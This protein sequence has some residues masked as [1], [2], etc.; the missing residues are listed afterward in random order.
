MVH[1]VAF[2]IRNMKIVLFAGLMILNMT[3]LS[4]ELTLQLKAACRVSV[5]HVLKVLL[6]GH[7]TR[8]NNIQ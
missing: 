5:M 4:L 6:S 8:P 1:S 2:E 3:F 7:I